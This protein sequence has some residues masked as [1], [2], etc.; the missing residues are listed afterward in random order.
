MT[1]KQG[2]QFNISVGGAAITQ[3]GSETQYSSSFRRTGI[4]REYYVSDPKLRI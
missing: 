2:R 4:R 3:L 1:A